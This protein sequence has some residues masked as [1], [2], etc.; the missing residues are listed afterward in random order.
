MI[1][2]QIL[3]K[4]HIKNIAFIHLNSKQK[5]EKDIVPDAYLDA[6]TLSE[7]EH[8]W[9]NWIDEVDGYIAFIEDQPAGFITFGNV[10]TRPPGDQGIIPLYS[11]EI[12]ALYVLPKF[13]RAGIGTTLLKAAMKNLAEAKHNGVVLWV[14]KNNKSSVDFYLEHDGLR[15]GKQKVEMGGRM[16]VES[17]IA[18]RKLSKFN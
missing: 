3:S 5:A 7:F 11:A 1:E 4:K 16:V 18:W 2:L 13:W 9:T 17:A 10:R 15:V 8:N 12:Y 6:L 14:L